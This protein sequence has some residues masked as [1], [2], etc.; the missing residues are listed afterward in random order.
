MTNAAL[1]QQLH[2][3]IDTTDDKKIEALYTIHQ[4]DKDK[5]YSYSD[6]ELQMLHERAEN[7]L[8]GESKAYTVEESHNKIRKQR[9]KHEL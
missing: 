8:H 4:V 7:Y 5:K 9:I 1:R 3:Y 6:E 2:R